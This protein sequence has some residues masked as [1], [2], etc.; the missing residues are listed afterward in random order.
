MENTL[1]QH[2]SSYLPK[3]FHLTFLVSVLCSLIMSEFRSYSGEEFFSA[4][5]PPRVFIIDDLLHERD[6]V[7]IVGGEKSGKSIL[8]FQ[9]ICSLT[10]QHP[11]LD[12]YVVHRACNVSYIQVEGDISDYQDRMK[13]MAQAQ[14]IDLKRVH[15]KF[16]A[17]MNL[18]DTQQ[19]KELIKEIESYHIPDVI[20][21][22]PLYFLLKGSLSDDDIV[23]QF[24]GNI[25]LI[26]EHFNCAII[27]IH[28]AH[29]VKTDPH[30]VIIDEGDNA[31][32]GSVLFKAFVDHL[33]FLTKNK[34]TGLR[35]M[36]CD[37]QRS[38]GIVASKTLKL[39]EPSPLYFE[40]SE[41]QLNSSIK[42]I[43]LLNY[44]KQA[45]PQ[46]YKQIQEGMPIS[47]STFYYSLKPL[48]IQKLVQKDTSVTPMLYKAL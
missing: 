27:I 39:V 26:K 5:F 19:V 18:T 36:T 37:T 22:D 44:L 12:K 33:I 4:N 47:S 42:S 29:K 9:F 7:F 2:I 20:I 23:R 48:I 1:C 45:G 30:G 11:F 41:S 15:Y 32:F 25:R 34:V 13:R 43:D 8:A 31:I 24:L 14:E 28:H 21:F 38:G 35:R 16:S 6:S 17:P 3:Y 40:I 46:T 10:S